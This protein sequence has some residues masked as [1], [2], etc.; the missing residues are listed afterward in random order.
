MNND[1]IDVRHSPE[2]Q[3]ETIHAHFEGHAY[4]VHWHDSYLVG[5]T[6]QGTQQF[7]CRRNKITS[8][9][10]DIF[11][12]EPGEIH[13]GDAPIEGGFTYQTFYLSP[14]W[15]DREIRHLFHDTPSSYELSFAKTLN[16]DPRLAQ[17]IAQTFQLLHFG[18]FRI[19]QQSALDNL[20]A[21]LAPHIHWRAEASAAHLALGCAHLAREYM[22]A[23]LNEDLSLQELAA[24]TGTDRFT[25]T[26]A[27]KQAFGIAPHAYL[28]Q[29]RLAEARI[30][31]SQGE[32]PV[33]VA[34]E[35]GFADQ[36]HLGR[37]FRR[38]YRLSPA[39]YRQI[40]T[41]LPD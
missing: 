8:T 28:V 5:V 3:I 13:D 10:G 7:H 25:L 6:Q 4:D 36:S 24:A 22:H 15:L 18:E 16:S 39:Q 21:H 37:W 23:H 40:C 19:V 27:F 31:L 1:W 29:L 33:Q 34:A 41:N 2:Y 14:E 17:A 30:R 35:L 38:A 26:R 11:L 20:L 12:L 9:P 32:K